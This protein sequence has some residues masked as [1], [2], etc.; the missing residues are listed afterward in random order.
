LLSAPDSG[1]PTSTA[2]AVGQFQSQLAA[3]S[4]GC[5]TDLTPQ[6]ERSPLFEQR[7]EPTIIGAGIVEDL[8]FDLSLQPF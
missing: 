7:A 4:Q 5:S 8:Y 1:G 2:I 3:E 6:T